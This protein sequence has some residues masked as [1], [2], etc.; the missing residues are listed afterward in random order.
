M[1]RY[2]LRG[3][4]RRRS[5]P[6]TKSLIGILLVL[7]HEKSNCPI[8]ASVTPSL[9]LLVPVSLQMNRLSSVHPNVRMIALSEG[10]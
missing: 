4:R 6:V 7:A 10:L 1:L 8:Q 3:K 9:L 2:D 5:E